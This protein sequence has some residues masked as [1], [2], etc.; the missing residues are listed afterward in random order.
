MPLAANHALAAG[1]QNLTKVDAR[2]TKVDKS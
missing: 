2:L 1:N